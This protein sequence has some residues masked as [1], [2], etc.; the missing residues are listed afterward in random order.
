VDTGPPRTY[1][2]GVT[3]TGDPRRSDDAARS[4]PDQPYPGQGYQGDPGR[5]SVPTP[6]D[7]PTAGPTAPPYVYNPYGNVSYPETYPAPPA[8]LGPGDGVEPARRPGSV[9][10][11]LVLLVVSVL[12]YLLVGFLAVAAAGTVESAMPPDQLAQLQQVGVD[13]E[14]VV[15]AT[16]VLLLGVALIYLV[17]AVLAFTGRRWARALLAAMTAG[18][19]LMAFASVAAASSQGLAIDGGSL[20]VIGGPALLAV[21]GVA[22][23]FG[24]AARAWFARSRRP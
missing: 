21:V 11:A 4:G 6:Y 8:G 2:G 22:L 14:Q 9:T 5:P 19:V 15:R 3:S 17:L 10:L 7:D 20:L 16:G 23:M 1:R 18:F 13:V 24:A 12:P